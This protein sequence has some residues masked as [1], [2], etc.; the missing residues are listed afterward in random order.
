VASR[1]TTRKLYLYS[2]HAHVRGQAIDDYRAL[3]VDLSRL[4]VRQRS[5]RTPAR[6]IAVR[7]LI[8]GG[9]YVRMTAYEGPPGL[10]PLIFD[11]GADEER[12]EELS[13]REVMATR[14]H[15]LVDLHTRDVVVEYNHRGAKA[16]DIAFVLEEAGRRLARR[17]GLT[18][19]FAPVPTPDFA[20]AIGDFETIKIASLNIVRPNLN[21]IREKRHADALADE[22]N[23]QRVEVSVFAGR[24]ETL[25]KTKGLVGLIKA[26]G[27]Q[28]RSS[29]KNASV[30]GRRKGEQSDTTISLARHLE[31]R[32]VRVRIG[33]GGHPLGD[34]VE[35]RIEEF[36]KARRRTLARR[37]TKNDA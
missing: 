29:L 18:L 35:S 34:S 23:G 6:L 4:T 25:Y 17:A 12:I 37:R 27:R 3:F 20:R 14:T 10:S 1:Y 28:P 32:N 8:V 15:A 21:W 13:E 16:S 5:H 33:P 22:S 7:R 11:L 31:H 2:A 36:L 26:L 19:E 9:D 24:N 30:S